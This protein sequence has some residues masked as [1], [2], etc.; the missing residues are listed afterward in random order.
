MIKYYERVGK[1]LK[2]RPEHG[3]ICVVHSLADLGLD[4][5]TCGEGTMP[6]KSLMCPKCKS[7]YN[8]S[9]SLMRQR[10]VYTY[11]RRWFFGDRRKVEKTFE[12]LARFDD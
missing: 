3:T 4:C 2:A 8:H 7:G 1:Q 12:V 11:E 9:F 5:Q 10:I 6:A